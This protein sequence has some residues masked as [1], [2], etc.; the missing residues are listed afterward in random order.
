M[1]QPNG[2]AVRPADI[3]PTMASQMFTKFEEQITATT[4]LKSVK[5]E[6]LVAIDMKTKKVVRR[7]LAFTCPMAIQVSHTDKMSVEGGL[8]VAFSAAFPSKIFDHCN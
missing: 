6:T 3:E 5:E 2:R 1:K 8:K 7:S 4:T